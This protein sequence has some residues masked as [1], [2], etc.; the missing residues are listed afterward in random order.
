MLAIKPGVDVSGITPEM[1]LGVM[2]LADVLWAHGIPTVIT[3]CRDGKHMEGSL[4]YVGKGVDTRL[5][6]RFSTIPTIDLML[7]MEARESLGSNYDLLLEGDHY[8]LEF[9]PKKE[10]TV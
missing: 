6:S 4:H 9:D 8:H 5:P 1:M 2:V 7:L 3:S 10:P